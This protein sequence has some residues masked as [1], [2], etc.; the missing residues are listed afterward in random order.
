MTRVQL[1]AHALATAYTKHRAASRG[2]ARFS[3]PDI[4]PTTWLML[5]QGLDPVIADMVTAAVKAQ[6]EAA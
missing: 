2:L 1:L 3:T 4:A 6:R 5:A